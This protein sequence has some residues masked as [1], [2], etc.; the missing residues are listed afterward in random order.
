M[1]PH[2][3]QPD[4]S[5]QERVEQ[6][7]HAKFQSAGQTYLRQLPPALG[8]DLVTARA[9][10]SAPDFPVSLRWAV[11]ILA[12]LTVGLAVWWNNQ[13]PTGS[14][15]ATGNVP[16]PPT[17]AQPTR[18]TVVAQAVVTPR[19]LNPRL[20]SER[21]LTP[22]A[23]TNSSRLAAGTG[24]VR[25]A[26]GSLIATSTGPQPL[27]RDANQPSNPPVL[28]AS[29]GGL[30]RGPVIQTWP[31]QPPGDGK[32]GG[33]MVQV[34][35]ST[36]ADTVLT[37]PAARPP[38]AVVQSTGNG[39]T[40]SATDLDPNTEY[41]VLVQRRGAPVPT[42]IGLGSS[43]ARGALTMNLP[44]A[45]LAATGASAPM[46]QPGVAAAVMLTDIETVLVRD[47]TTGA[48]VLQTVVP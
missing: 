27:R 17:G 4:Q 13:P 39:L 34:G 46:D 8:A 41:A 37:Q 32:R 14:L 10:E 19:A 44:A 36:L 43:D 6:W 16:A 35:G 15:V 21:D 2:S 45:V 5:D 7:L 23:A 26:T 11:A 33:G 22:S 24:P 9:A 25:P 12:I 38:V 3:R 20:I 18:R 40:L 1:N 42:Q 47:E 29:G 31:L 30:W 28:V 48:I